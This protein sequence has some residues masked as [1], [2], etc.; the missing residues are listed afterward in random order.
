MVGKRKIILFPKRGQSEYDEGDR[1]NWIKLEDENQK[2]GYHFPRGRTVRHAS[3]H[4]LLGL[5]FSLLCLWSRQ[6][7]VPYELQAWRARIDRNSLE[8]E[9]EWKGYRWI[10][11]AWESW[12]NNWDRK[13]ETKNLRRSI[14]PKKVPLPSTRSQGI[15]K[16]PCF[17][18]VLLFESLEDP[19]Q[20]LIRD[21]P[22]IQSCPDP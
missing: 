3:V 5:C 10:P 16:W 21:N 7:Q 12:T 14:S 2:N 13:R 9:I 6:K 17:R 4:A 11:E 15:T 1:E 18:H 19:K 8:N 22:F 20:I